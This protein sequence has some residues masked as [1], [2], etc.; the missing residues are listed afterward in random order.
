MTTSATAK[1]SEPKV[2]KKDPEFTKD[3]LRAIETT[4]DK[5]GTVTSVARDATFAEQIMVLAPLVL[6]QAIGIVHSAE[7]GSVETKGNV[8]TITLVAR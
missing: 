2:D 3:G 4:T 7:S 8:L 6:E 5:D 1:K